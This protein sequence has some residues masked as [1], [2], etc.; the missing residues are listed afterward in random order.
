M[1]DGDRAILRARAAAAIAALSGFRKI[2]R[3][4]RT[5]YRVRQTRQIEGSERRDRERPTARTETPS[6][7]CNNASARHPPNSA[8][9]GNLFDYRPQTAKTSTTATTDA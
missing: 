8:R 5:D 2:A 7:C 6:V 1:A 9:S 3:G 4:W